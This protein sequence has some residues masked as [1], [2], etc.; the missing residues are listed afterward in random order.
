VING[1]WFPVENHILGT[2]LQRKML[3]EVLDITHLVGELGLLWQF[4]WLG[5][6]I[7]IG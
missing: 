6:G 7:D 2:H 5:E 3:G 1:P 4:N